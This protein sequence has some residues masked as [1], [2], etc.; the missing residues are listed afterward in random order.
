VPLD[1]EIRADAD[2]DWLRVPYKD[3]CAEI[4]TLGGGKVT[5]Q[6]PV[7]ECELFKVDADVFPYVSQLGWYVKRSRANVGAA[8]PDWRFGKLA[9]PE[10]LHRWI[11]RTLKGNPRNDFYGQAEFINGDRRDCRIS[12][13]RWTLADWYFGT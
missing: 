1:S 13:L 8:Q 12:N 10:V 3:G 9:A 5:W 2:F 7:S 4:T 11:L 6:H